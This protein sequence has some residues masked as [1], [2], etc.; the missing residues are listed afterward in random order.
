MPE[1][2]DRSDVLRV[3][4]L[5]PEASFSHQAAV[6]VFLPRQRPGLTVSLHPLPSFASIFSAIQGSLPNHGDFDYAIVPMENSTNGSVVQ[7]LD[8]LAQCGLDVSALYP[9]LEV[10]AEYYLPVHHYLFVSASSA[11]VASSNVVLNGAP[12]NSSSAPPTKQDPFGKIQTLH[13]HPQVW[14]QCTRF[15]SEKFLGT[16]RIDVGSTSTAAQIAS[17]DSSGRNAAIASRLAGE[18]NGLRCL[19]ENIEDE[20][21][22]NTT[23]F[24]VVR[25]KRRPV[26]KDLFSA[27][28]T[29]TKWK[30]LITFTVPHSLPGSLAEALAVF[31]RFHFNLTRIDTR[32]GRKRNWQY[33]FFV[34]C[35]E[36]RVAGHDENL[37]RMLDE[38]GPHTESLRYLGSL[39]DQLQEK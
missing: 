3:A 24:F 31:K 20:P 33:V 6:D 10:C 29:E 28:T 26:G 32:P 14:G 13:T 11:S 5:G 36:T 7:V 15:L 27:S 4:Y 23:R 38:L 30:S 9:D 12:V 21:G 16:E 25:N 17:R 34:E 35:E 1:D 37:Q 22:R 19:A 39:V 18:L 8:L 2:G